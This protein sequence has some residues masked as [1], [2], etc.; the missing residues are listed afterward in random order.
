VVKVDLMLAMA[1]VIW[2][3]VMFVSWA[4]EYDQPGYTPAQ[5]DFYVRVCQARHQVPALRYNAYDK[6]VK[7]TCWGGYVGSSAGH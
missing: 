7:I 5:T 3:C 4:E 1:L 6:V 2:F